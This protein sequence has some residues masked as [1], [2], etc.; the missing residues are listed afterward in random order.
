MFVTAFPRRLH[1]DSQAGSG[2][3]APAFAKRGFGTESIMKGAGRE[4]KLWTPERIR[5]LRQ[6]LEMT[7]ENFAHLIGV[8]FSSVNRWENGKA[9]PNKIALR[10]ISA[11]ERKLKRQMESEMHPGLESTAFAAPTATTQ[12]IKPH[13]AISWK[14]A[15]RM[16]GSKTN[17]VYILRM[18]YLDGIP[19]EGLAHE[20]GVT[21]A[22]VNRWENGGTSPNKVAKKVLRLLAIKAGAPQELIEG[23]SSM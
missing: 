15:L 1:P 10:V 23:I 8:T 16:V 5:D 17:P 21:Y 14:E 13:R 22:T 20:I 19:Q 6:R 3:R 11:L 7:Q 4:N 9:R 18:V 12:V 2:G